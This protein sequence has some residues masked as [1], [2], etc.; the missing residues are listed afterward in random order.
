MDRI[1]I[2]AVRDP[3][4]GLWTV[5]CPQQPGLVTGGHSLI[6]AIIRGADA[7]RELA[8]PGVPA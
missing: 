8:R 4:T 6:V 3:A 7:L 2:E 1:T 5:T